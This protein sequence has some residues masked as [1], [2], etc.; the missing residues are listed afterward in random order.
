MTKIALIL[1]NKTE[2]R[3]INGMDWYRLWMPYYGLAA[4]Y[5]V[6]ALSTDEFDMNP[7]DCDIYVIN[8]SRELFRAE[9][10]KKEGKKLI[11]DIDDYW[12]L[13]T[14]HPMHVKNL[15]KQLEYAKTH[16]VNHDDLAYTKQTYAVEK[17]AAVNIV[18]SIEMADAVTCTV[19][20]LA[21]KIREINPNVYIIRNT[22]HP[23][24]TQ[25][26][27]TK[28]RS[29]RLRFGYFGGVF[30]RRDVALMFDGITKLH[31]DKA[32]RDKY[33]FVSAFNSNMD[34]VEIEKMFTT[35]YAVVSNEY[36]DLLRC[37]TQ[38]ASHIGLNEPYMRV[39]G[40]PVNE[41]GRLYQNI[42]VALIPLQHGEFNSMKSELK[43]VEAGATGCAAIVSD[44]EPYSEWLKHGKNCLTTEGTNGWYSAF[45][46]CLNNPNLVSD[47]R[48]GLNAT[49]DLH[50]NSDNEKK[51]LKSLIESLCKSE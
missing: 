44:V 27:A 40:V 28:Q 4:D 19:D 25:Y 34:Y 14:W 13:P 10:V 9:R 21:D 32:E 20:K 22:I 37:N 45:K 48:D 1:N 30:H 31:R 46:M 50:F 23:D 26:S 15:E 12:H 51:I 24:F 5:E 36:R 43:L 18:K 39:W 38:V 6:K 29:A 49:I 16:K 11:V 42:H 41:Y 17:N 7:L 3:P 47:L 8:R 35:N 33:Q 2:A